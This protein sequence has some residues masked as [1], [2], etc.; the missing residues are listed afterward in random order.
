MYTYKIYTGEIQ[1]YISIYMHKNRQYQVLAETQSSYN[2]HTSLLG[3][4]NDS[5]FGK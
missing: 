5:H 4:K 1:M 2:S 3:M